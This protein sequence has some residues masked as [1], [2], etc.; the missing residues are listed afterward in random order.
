MLKLKKISENCHKLKPLIYFEDLP[1]LHYP[2]Y[3]DKGTT[4]ERRNRLIKVQCRPHLRHLTGD[5][6]KPG[7]LAYRKERWGESPTV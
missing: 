1:S 5:S 3:P 4:R 7:W 2:F 6:H